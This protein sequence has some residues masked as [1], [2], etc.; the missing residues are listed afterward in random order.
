M[1]QFL[2]IHELCESHLIPSRGSL[3]QWQVSKLSELCYLY[4]LALRVMLLQD[5]TQKWAR[6]YCHQVGEQNDFDSWRNTANDL[7][8]MLYALSDPNSGAKGSLKDISISTSLIR[9]WLRHVEDEDR[10][11]QFLMRIDGMLH[12]TDSMMKSVQRIIMNWEDA[13]SRERKDVATKLITWIHARAP[14][15]S[16]LLPE[17]KKMA[18]KLKESA[19]AGATSVGSVATAV[20][21]LG[22]GFDPD[23]QDKSIYKQKK[24]VVLRRSSE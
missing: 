9:Q 8:A 19:T 11:R 23:G 16:E 13:N 17:L 6:D 24:P 18:G 4:F 22:A 15:N 2:F 20:G 10:T 7:Y 14:S 21:G 12:I 3:K 1:T 5:D